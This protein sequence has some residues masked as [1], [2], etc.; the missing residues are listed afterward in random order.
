[1]SDTI[2]RQDAIDEIRKCRFVVDAIEK[3]IGLSSAQPE[4]IRCKDCIYWWESNKLCKR[5]KDK[6]H[7]CACMDCDA[8]FYCKYAERR[9]DERTD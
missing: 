4:I 3:I 6:N 9:T 8:D 5:N 7:N 1:M 2:S